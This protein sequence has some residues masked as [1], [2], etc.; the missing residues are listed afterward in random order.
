VKGEVIDQYQVVKAKV[1]FTN[2]KEPEVQY[3]E[4][5]NEI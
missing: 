5:Y 1:V 3:Q 4:D 2:E